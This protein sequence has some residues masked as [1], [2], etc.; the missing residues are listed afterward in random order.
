LLNGEAS[1]LAQLFCFWKL[2][3]RY[4]PKKKKIKSNRSRCRY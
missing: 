4:S 3:R 2:W 1:N